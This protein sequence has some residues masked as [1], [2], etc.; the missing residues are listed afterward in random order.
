MALQAL[1][2]IVRAIVLGVLT[3]LV[4]TVPLGCTSAPVLARAPNLYADS[5]DDPYAAVPAALQT[6]AG[7]CRWRA[8]PTSTL[9]GFS[10]PTI[11]PT[12]SPA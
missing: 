7:G 10:A 3:A 12:S 8:E 5:P 2:R 6:T 4:A 1:D 11:S 9:T